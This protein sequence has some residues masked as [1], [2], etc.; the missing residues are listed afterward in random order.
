[1]TY[2]LLWLLRFR[3]TFVDDTNHILYVAYVQKKNLKRISYNA[4][5]L[6]RHCEAPPGWRNYFLITQCLFSPF[7]LK[8]TCVL[9]AMAYFCFP[10]HATE[11]SSISIFSLWKLSRCKRCL[12]FLIG[13]YFLFQF[14]L[15]KV[16]YSYY[17]WID[18][19]NH[20]QE[21]WRSSPAPPM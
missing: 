14:Y 11:S 15:E 3:L 6:Y 19:E 2:H 7:F 10:I 9:V 12:R 1:M 5:V 4:G 8:I 20:L 16:I 21:L 13:G 17:A 18:S